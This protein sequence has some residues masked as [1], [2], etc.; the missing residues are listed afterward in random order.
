MHHC[1]SYNDTPQYY[2]TTCPVCKVYLILKLCLKK[3][4]KILNV[5]LLYGKV[6]PDPSS[7]MT[8]CYTLLSQAYKPN[9][10]A[11]VKLT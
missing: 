7:I 10:F 5:I 2:S 4:V 3:A 1:T 6:W 11:R 9:N 8:W